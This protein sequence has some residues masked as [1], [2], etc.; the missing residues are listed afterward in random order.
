[1]IYGREGRQRPSTTCWPP[2]PRTSPAHPPAHSEP[3][4]KP[5]GSRAFSYELYYSA[6][7][8][9]LRV[10]GAYSTFPFCSCFMQDLPL[11]FSYF[12]ASIAWK[13]ESVSRKNTLYFSSWKI[14]RLPSRLYIHVYGR[15]YGLSFERFQFDYVTVAH[16]YTFDGIFHAQFVK[17]KCLHAP[18]LYEYIEKSLFFPSIVFIFV[19]GVGNVRMVNNFID[20]AN[21]DSTISFIIYFF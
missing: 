4:W 19:L 17:E 10:E 3:A 7:R 15:V 21:I 5:S 14:T 8:R 6:R 11:K 18:Q 9:P 13:F 16:L 12:F 1:M 20:K 2:Q